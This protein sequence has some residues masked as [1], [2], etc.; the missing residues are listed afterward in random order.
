MCVCVCVLV[1]VL[2]EDSLKMPGLDY[3]AVIWRVFGVLG[4][5][6]GLSIDCVLCITVKVVTLRL[7]T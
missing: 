6:N 3:S 7:F 2:G 5:G 1:H 4:K